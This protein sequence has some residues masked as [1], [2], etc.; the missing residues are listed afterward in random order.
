MHVLC[1]HVVFPA[2]QCLAAA[3]S[4][5]SGLWGALQG[6]PG[7]AAGEASGKH[8]NALQA[9]A[10]EGDVSLKV[11]EEEDEEEEGSED[12]AGSP[13][14]YKDKKLLLVLAGCVPC[15]H[16]NTHRCQ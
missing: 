6:G 1:M 2:T 13:P 10:A 8:V 7:G 11:E 9:K 5:D 14:W 15:P 16:V 4:S 3:H 12:Y